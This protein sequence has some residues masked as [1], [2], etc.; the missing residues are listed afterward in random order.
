MTRRVWPTATAALPGPRAQPED[1]TVSLVARHGF[2]VGGVDDPDGEL[3]LQEIEDGFPIA[4][5]RLHR[6]VCGAVGTQPVAEGEQLVR[7][8]S[9]RADLCRAPA[10]R[11]HLEETRHDGGVVHIRSAAPRILHLHTLHPL[12][13]VG[14]YARRQ[15]LQRCEI[16]LRG[17]CCS[18][19]HRQWYRARPRSDCC[20]GSM[21]QKERDR[22]SD[23]S[24]FQ[25]YLRGRDFSSGTVAARRGDD[26]CEIVSPPSWPL[27]R[28]GAET[29]ANASSF[30]D[31]RCDVRHPAASRRSAS[32]QCL[33]RTVISEAGLRGHPGVLPRARRRLDVND[34]R[35]TRVSTAPSRPDVPS[36]AVRSAHLLSMSGLL[37]C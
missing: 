14:H 9:E 6:D 2:D 24:T 4:T 17:R 31:K 25:R 19:R 35:D 20:G 30:V 32:L 21:H 33:Q 28:N 37:S 12:P 13:V 18:S 29:Y 16:R 5:S 34:R 15:A 23:P 3:A 10:V 26:C 7:R 36:A 27:S 1:G 22:G 11:I 8:R